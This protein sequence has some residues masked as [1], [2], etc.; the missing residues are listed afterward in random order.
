MNLNS[1]W[2]RAGQFSPILRVRWRHN[3]FP[4]SHRGWTNWAKRKIKLVEN[5]VALPMAELKW[6][7]LLLFIFFLWLLF[8]IF[9]SVTS[10]LL[11]GRPLVFSIPS[12]WVGNFAGWRCPFCRNVKISA[13]FLSLGVMLLLL[14]CCCCCS[15][16]CRWSYGRSLIV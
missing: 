1:V 11:F 8:C 9:G 7:L 2:M 10:H 15:C 3:S 6:F 12:D 13:R 14:C 16:C 5:S 4:S